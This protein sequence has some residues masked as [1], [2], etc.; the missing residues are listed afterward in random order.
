MARTF[1]RHRSVI[2][3]SGAAQTGPD[4]HHGTVNYGTTS[5]IEDLC[6]YVGLTQVKEK[7]VFLV[8]IFH[9]Y[10]TCAVSFKNFHNQELSLEA[11][12]HQTR[13]F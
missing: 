2:L 4:L 8:L 5:A 3:P 6:S 9:V 7:R 10:T 13:G 1:W 11:A 12:W